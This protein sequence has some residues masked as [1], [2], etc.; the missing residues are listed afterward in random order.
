[1]QF[2][3]N[4]EFF[5]DLDFIIEQMKKEKVKTILLQLPD[6]LKENAKEIVDYLNRKGFKVF[7]WGGSNWGACDIP[8]HYKISFIDAIIHIGHLPFKKTKYYLQ[9]E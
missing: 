3:L 1:M 7:I 6:G 8:T 4:K 2:K 5:K 9:R